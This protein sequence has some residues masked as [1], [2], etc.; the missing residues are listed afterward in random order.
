MRK[1]RDDEIKKTAHIMAECFKDY[2]LYNVF[3]KN[4]QK[5]VKRIFYF[6][7]IRMYT[8]KNYSYIT[9]N[10]DIVVS[11]Q[12]P[13]DKT[14]SSLGLFLNPV[15][16]IGFL[17]NIPIK[18]LFKVKK[19]SDM[20][21]KY[22]NKYYNPHTDS[23]AHAICVLKQSRGDIDIFK[24][25]KDLDDGRPIY[26]ETHTDENVRLYELMGAK[27]CSEELFEGVK[28]TVLKKTGK[29]LKYVS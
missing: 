9:D 10:E 6:F 19:Y 22:L 17:I 23:Y 25:L 18:S 20:S 5:K 1:I 2:P 15:F 8:R 26:C 3:F 12:K 24:V 13:E 27:I 16:L 11:F 21:N 14:I 29:Y 7:W 28:H 4:D